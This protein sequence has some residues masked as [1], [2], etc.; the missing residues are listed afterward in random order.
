MPHI[1]IAG[2]GVAGLEA[3]LALRA[4]AGERVRLTLV[5][6]DPDFTYKP[7]ATAEPFGLG[8]AH[9]VPLTRFAEQA[10]AELVID[11]IA[12]LDTDDEGFIRVDD[13]GRVAGCERTWAAGDGVASPLKFGGVATHQA[14]RIAA[15]IARSTGA[16]APDP[17]EPVLHGRLL[18]GNGS[19]R[20]RGRGDGEPA[21]LWWPA[22]K[23][24][25][26]YLPRWL[27]EHGLAP[28]GQVEEPP[29]GLEIR[30]PLRAM[31]AAEA[32]YLADLQRPTATR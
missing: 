16:D 19:R 27:A 24:A 5:A 30:R 2:G 10:R 1:I 28:R 32:R 13:I 20:L 6:P 21:P 14:R 25:G 29:D 23:I 15:A 11:A 7:L 4:M 8:H 22:G 18:T 3:L 12:G 9:S 31:R 17:G 26:L